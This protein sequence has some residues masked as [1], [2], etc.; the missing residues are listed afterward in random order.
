MLTGLY[1]PSSGDASIYGMSLKS[2]MYSIRQFIGVCPQHD[3]L[4]GSL[5]V[6][7]HLRFYGQLKCPWLSAEELQ[8]K[9]FRLLAEVGLTE[10]VDAPSTS[11]S[12]GQKRKLSLAIALVGEGKV[13]ILDE[14]TSGMDPYS[15]RSTWNTLRAAREGRCMILTTHFMDEADL[16]GDRIGIMAEG[17][18]RCCGSSL[19]LKNKF[20]AGYTLTIVK[21]RTCNVAELQRLV[22]GSISGALLLSNVG[23]EISFRLPL[24]ALA[25][26]SELFGTF[27]EQ[28]AALGIEQFGV[29]ITTMEE[30]FIRIAEE[31]Q[32]S[33][34]GTEDEPAAAADVEAPA[35][36]SATVLADDFG[37]ISAEDQQKSEFTRHFEALLKKRYRYG[38]RD[39]TAVFCTTLL[40]VFM[41]LLGL[42]MLK[43][44]SLGQLLDQPMLKLDLVGAGYAE[45]GESLTVPYHT[46]PSVS[47][48]FTFEGVDAGLPVI[49]K[50]VDMDPASSTGLFGGV[51]YKDGMP[52]HPWNPRAD[53]V[54]DYDRRHMP[55]NKVGL[56]NDP[57]SVVGMSRQLMATDFAEANSAVFGSL[58]VSQLE[59]GTNVCGLSGAT[60]ITTDFTPIYGGGSPENLQDQLLDCRMTITA[61]AGHVIH[62]SFVTLDVDRF[63]PIGINVYDGDAIDDASKIDDGHFPRAA[64]TEGRRHRSKTHLPTVTSR[65]NTLTLTQSIAKTVPAGGSADWLI[66]QTPLPQRAWTAYVSFE[67]TCADID[68]ACSDAVGTVTQYGITCEMTLGELDLD[69][70]E[71]PPDLVLPTNPATGQPFTEAEVRTL[72]RDVVIP[73]VAARYGTDTNLAA[74]C[75]VS[76]DACDSYSGP[77][78]PPGEMPAPQFSCNATEITAMRPLCA[79]ALAAPAGSFCESACFTL[80]LGPWLSTCDSQANAVFNELGYGLSLLVGPLLALGE[81]CEQAEARP[82]PS[83]GSLQCWSG[84]YTQQ[85][86]CNTALGA[87]GDTE[88]WAPPDYTFT[89][90]CP[91]AGEGASSPENNIAYTLLYNG[92]SKHAS[93][94]FANLMSNAIQGPGGSITT[95]NHPLPQT[96]SSQAL[97]DNLSSL[98]A[99]LFILIAFSFVP[100]GIVV[101]VVREKESHHN[102]KHQQMV[103]GVRIPSYWLSNFVWD[104]GLYMLPLAL[105]MMCIKAVGLK[106]FND[107]G[108]FFAC[109]VLLLGFGWAAAP[110]TYVVSFA[111]SSHTKAQIF[112]ALFN[113]FLGMGL[114][115]AYYV[116]SLIEQTVEMNTALLPYYRLSPGF[117]LGHGLWSISVQNLVHDYLG[118]G[119]VLSPLSPAIA[120]DDVWALF[121]MGPIYL[122]SAI[123]IDYLLSYPA[124]AARLMQYTQSSI[125]A[126][127]DPPIPDEDEDVVAEER[128]LA[129]GG[130]VEDG[131]LIRLQQLRKV[132][133]TK[134]SHKVAVRGASFSVRAGECFGY[135]GINGAGKTST[136]KMLTGD[137]LPTSGQ[138]FLGGMDILSQQR[139][140]RR[141]IGYCPQFDALLDRLTVREHLELF[142]RIRGVSKEGLNDT[143]LTAM[144][145]MDLTSFEN[146]LAGTLSGGNKRKLSVAIALIGSPPIVF[147]DEPT[148]SAFCH[149]AS[150]PRLRPADPFS[151]ADGC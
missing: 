140:V 79:A 133:K 54:P 113:I 61:P 114:M 108:A 33:L 151:F 46:T 31:N 40:P 134:K 55:A 106:T 52:T 42:L 85:R 115:I 74:A 100:A 123:G 72:A 53:R 125:R 99:V 18:L 139:E 83:A 2:D 3:V 102:S 65:T 129:A 147:L 127:E 70:I 50:P 93:P 69:T 112:T 17:E 124:V 77:L 23:A 7:E 21:A 1:E 148:V 144:S 9:I 13:V 136:M 122:A 51:D 95:R 66:Q 26:F 104:F 76:C 68:I 39:K 16:L 45:Y 103:S 58:L 43:Y 126:L 73:E 36:A 131:E 109:F 44:G 132:Y 30:V 67:A 32:H 135:L 38:R 87:T 25:N 137:V 8:D 29:S 35:D 84:D 92:T 57:E 5:T 14:P 80:S 4:F 128:R 96:A 64:D 90:C 146:K 63:P 98:Q 15:R 97:I 117:C 37:R 12:G 145:R 101:F 107:A 34:V 110:F 22:H 142:A 138:A 82:Q 60:A 56:V 88:C 48:A 75:P 6:S 62:V 130:P 143:V 24:A 59:E 28:K 116:M 10:K 71:L 105:S 20:G 141:L 86:C 91:A 78:A 27:D 47:P 118:E 149:C 150:R 49:P 94:I 41:L 81:A 119:I 89:T 121:V 11:L 120:G 19:Y 111:Y